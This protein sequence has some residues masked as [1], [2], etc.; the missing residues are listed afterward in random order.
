MRQFTKEAEEDQQTDPMR[1]GRFFDHPVKKVAAALI[2]IGSF[3]FFSSRFWVSPRLTPVELESHIVTKAGIKQEPIS[4][5]IYMPGTGK[6]AYPAMVIINSSGGVSDHIERYYANQ[7]TA[8]G[9][10]ALVVD[11]FTGRGIK[12]TVNDQTQISAWKMEADAFAALAWL[13]QN[14]QIDPERIGVMGV[15]KGGGVAVNTALNERR[16]WAGRKEEPFSLHVAIAPPGHLQH[17]D[18]RTSNRPMLFMIGEMDDYAA[19]GPA[20]E[21]ADRIVRAGNARISVIIYPGVHHAWESIGKLRYLPLAE[22]GSNCRGLIESNGDVTMQT[23]HIRLSSQEYGKW[24]RTNCLT[25]GAHVGG[26]TE[27]MKARATADLVRFLK[28]N[29]TPVP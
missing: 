7:L 9:I 2:V 10:A 24:I 20:I 26:G 3:L 15:S 19:A 25:H 22:N 12:H 21:Y 4:A 17:R 8:N 5:V 27:E 11:S 18:A 28:A 6:N 16:K 13:R 23:D 14:P 1:S 29:W